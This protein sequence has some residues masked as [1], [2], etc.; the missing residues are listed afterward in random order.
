MKQLGRQVTL[1]PVVSEYLVD[2]VAVVLLELKFQQFFER[3]RL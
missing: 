2:A 1:R 3:V